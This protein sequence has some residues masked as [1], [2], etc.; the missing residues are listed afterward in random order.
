M[1]DFKTTCLGCE[2]SLLRQLDHKALLALLKTK[3]LDELT[4]RIQRFRMRLMRV[5]YDIVYTV[6]KNL[7]TADIV[8]RAPWS[9]PADQE[10]LMKTRQTPSSVQS[11]TAFPQM[12]QGWKRFD[13]SNALTKSAAK[14]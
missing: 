6:G 13:R 14:S 12:M 2:N 5:S 8:S 9:A 4:P 10:H 7:M 11:L 1:T 3:L